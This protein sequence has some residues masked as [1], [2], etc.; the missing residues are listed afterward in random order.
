V[1]YARL[2]VRKRISVFLLLL[3]VATACSRSKPPPVA[4][5]A[6]IS[7]AAINA[8]A[9]AAADMGNGWTAQ[10]DATVNTVQIGGR[11]GATN[12][13]G[14]PAQATTAFTQ[15]VGSGFVSDSVFLMGTAAL[16]RSV[17]DAHEQAAA[18][19]TWT[20][21][22]TE[23]GQ[24]AWKISGAIAGLDPP[25]GDQMFATRLHATITDAKGAKTAR[26][27]EYIVYRVGRVV[28]F[29]IAQDAGAASFARKQEAKVQRAATGTP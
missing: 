25:L 4:T 16:A 6:P 23:G 22:R 29:L 12:I 9:L 17:I 20:Q 1:R 15:K 26:N 27:V 14:P 28:A 3:I 2:N 8:A 18:T 24:T 5:Q 11:I 21:T 13:A 7:A 19:T 10:A